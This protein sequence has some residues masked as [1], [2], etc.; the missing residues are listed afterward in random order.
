M[1]PSS[2]IPAWRATQRDFFP[3]GEISIRIT[4]GFG[5]RIGFF[6]CHMDVWRQRPYGSQAVQLKGAQSHGGNKI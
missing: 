1:Q 4:S 3:E 2:R 5:A 6:P